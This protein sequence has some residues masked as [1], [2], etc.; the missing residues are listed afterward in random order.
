MTDHKGIPH[1]LTSNAAGQSQFMRGIEARAKE[2]N[3]LDNPRAPIPPELFSPRHW[4]A[5]RFLE[6]SVLRDPL[7]Y[8]EFKVPPA[9]ERPT[10]PIH[11]M[12]EEYTRNVARREAREQERIARLRFRGDLF[13]GWDMPRTVPYWRKS[14]FPEVYQVA[15]KYLDADGTPLFTQ[16]YPVETSQPGIPAL[17][18]GGREFYPGDY[19][20][21]DASG[22]TPI[23]T[24][25]GVV[26]GNVHLA[27]VAQNHGLWEFLK[28]K[29]KWGLAPGDYVI[30]D[31]PNGVKARRV[32][33][34]NGWGH[35]SIVTD[36]PDQPGHHDDHDDDDAWDE[37]EGQEWVDQQAH[38][39][40]EA[41]ASF[42]AE[43][44][45][46]PASPMWPAGYVAAEPL[47]GAVL[48]GTFDLVAL[49]GAVIKLLEAPDC[50]SCGCPELVHCED[51][52]QP[53]G[54]RCECAG[55]WAP[56]PK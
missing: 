31:L 13:A 55:Y 22:E 16:E 42:M 53:P 41:L 7:P 1:Y 37:A 47:T 38:D 51:G 54:A 45:A 23:Y 29:P 14:M 49:A 15:G 11:R 36:V 10:S 32:T 28:P 40:A 18:I 17:S 33:E 19:Q 56:D 48:D 44:L 12:I 5:D 25:P 52:C 20:C 8:R 21:V 30:E 6:D 4:M 35:V 3:S 34:G 2:L 43:H 46:S 24:H 9:P 26:P 39:R 27:N 50:V